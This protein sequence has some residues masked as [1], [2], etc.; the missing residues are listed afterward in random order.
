[1]SEITEKPTHVNI[2]KVQHYGKDAVKISF[3]NNKVSKKVYIGVPEKI[4]KIMSEFND[5]N[6]LLTKDL[7][8]TG[9]TE[10]VG[11][12]NKEQKVFA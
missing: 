3:T 11:R 9:N 12:Y 6:G 2:K 10:F 1:M 8:I 4:N 5:S 7:F